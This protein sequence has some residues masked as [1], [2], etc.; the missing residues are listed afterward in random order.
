MKGKNYTFFIASS[1]S[2]SM[3]RL[4]VPVYA[5]HALVALALVGS[6]TVVFAMG[7]YSRML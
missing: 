6:I 4:R 7:S 1:A 5:L 3:K 2:G